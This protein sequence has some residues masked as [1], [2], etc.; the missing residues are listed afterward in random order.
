MDIIHGA[1]TLILVKK[2]KSVDILGRESYEMALQQLIHR[3]K[4]LN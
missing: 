4:Y 3:N 1:K 2:N